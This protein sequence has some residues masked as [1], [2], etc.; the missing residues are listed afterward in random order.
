LVSRWT[1]NTSSLFVQ[2][3]PAWTTIG[4]SLIIQGVTFAG[5]VAL[6]R[7]L[8]PEARGQLAVVLLWPPLLAGLGAIG[9]AEA[10][11]YY[12][13]KEGTRRSGALTSAMGIG[14]P[15]SLALML[16]GLIILPVALTGKP[17]FVLHAA[18]LYLLVIPLYPLTL[19]PLAVLQGR[20]SF[21]SFN[22]ARIVVHIGYAALVMVLWLF[23]RLD[24]FAAMAASLVATLMSCIASLSLVLLHGYVDW[25]PTS[26]LFRSLLSFGAK[27]HVGNVAGVIGTRLDV[28]L[29]SFLPLATALGHYSVATSVASSVAL[30]PNAVSL[31]LY[32][33]VSRDLPHARPQRLSRVLLVGTVLTVAFVPLALIL[34]SP[35][36]PLVFGAAF[37]SAVPIAQVLIAGYLLRGW[38]AML[39]AVVR[40]AGH[41]FTASLGDVFN[42]VVFAPLLVILV[43]A[44]SGIGAGMALTAA[45][46]V[47][48]TWL[49]V[50]AFRLTGLTGR[51]MFETW[52]AELR[53]WVYDE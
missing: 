4:A 36:V 53:R 37:R 49:G 34:V 26:W 42:V 3:R 27:V 43:P 1:K 35:V 11:A 46:A 23:G 10:V 28:L 52:T 32:P 31:L 15:Q 47:Q 41:P 29:L 21:G 17:A 38:A 18:F 24:V 7:G 2:A 19:Y 13:T 44:A 39:A 33:A 22:V 48:V 30:I 9:I 20:L 8:G 50:Q 25:R 12:T 5:G 51:S 40:G 14:L 16:V 45:A 6:A